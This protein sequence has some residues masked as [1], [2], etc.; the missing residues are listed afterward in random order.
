M[1]SVERNELSYGCCWGV[2]AEK[3]ELS[4]ARADFWTF[5]LFVFWPS[6]S[7]DLRKGIFCHLNSFLYFFFQLFCDLNQIAQIKLECIM[8]IPT[9]ALDLASFW[10]GLI[11]SSTGKEILESMW[12]ADAFI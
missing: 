11:W 5:F 3:V 8:Y 4:D 7:A 9:K 12:K 10:G 1:L 6:I 2:K